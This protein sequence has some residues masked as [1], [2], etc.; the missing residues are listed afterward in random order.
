MKALKNIMARMG[1]DIKRIDKAP[2]TLYENDEIFWQLYKKAMGKTQMESDNFLRQQRHYL[3]LELLKNTDIQRGNIAEC[4]CFR[5]LS[6]YQIATRLK[7]RGFKKKFYL[8]DSFEGL[9]TFDKKDLSDYVA[10]YDSR[11]KEF[12]C[13]EDIVRGNLNEFNFIEYKKGWIP[14]RFNEVSEDTF[15]FVHIDVDLYE[16]TKQALEFFYPRVL[17]DGV[18]VFDDYGFLGFP[19][20]KQAVDEF[21]RDK[22]DFFISLP[23]SNAFL[24]KD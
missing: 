3:L 2:M 8:F 18:I 4:G 6:A 23:S 14:N 22:K 11:R 13:S 5:G 16:P 10:D 7:E 20:A 19:G 12:A 9:S 17:K 15:V 21:M 24:I 1:Y